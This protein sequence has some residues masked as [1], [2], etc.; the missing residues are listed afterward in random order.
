MKRRITRE[1]KVGGLSLGGGKPILIQSMTN[2]PAHDREQTLSQI[3]ALERAGCDVVRFTVPDLEVVKMIP[4][5]K[6]R[7]KAALVADIHFD[8]RLAV[9]SCEAGID[10]IR[11]NPGN[12]GS[13][14]KVR[15]VARAC[16]ER[17]IPIRIGVNSG[18]LE[19][20]LLEQ[21]GGPTAQALAQSGIEQ[22]AALEEFGFSQIAVSV[23]SSN[24]ITMIEA[25][26][27]LSQKTDYP[28]HLGVTE[29]GSEEMGSIKS[30]V[31]IG[32]LLCDGIGDTLRV[33]L[34][35]DVTK[36]AAAAR[37]ILLA[38]GLLESGVDVISCPTCGRTRID[39]I[40][41]VKQLEAALEKE[42]LRPKRL[43]RAAVMGCAVNGPGEAREADVGVAGGEGC[44]LLF[45]KG[46]I[47][48][49]ISEDSIVNTLMEEIRLLAKEG[50]TDGE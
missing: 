5:Y 43:I 21:F 19:K 37:K 44:A 20:R 39:L 12:I 6:A 24:V 31:G 18:S 50:N 2:A 4:Y 42:A 28:L 23:K 34:S 35:A 25:N 32:S 7:T 10:K 30:A 26:R 45:R 49:K 16:S 29:A 48:R 14:D 36:E 38:C 46:E 22:A 9:A 8:Y 17:G 47:L 13:K 15:E 1:L 40:G 3:L 41:I 33:S 27:I 11:I